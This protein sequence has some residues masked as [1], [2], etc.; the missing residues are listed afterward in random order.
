MFNP[1]SI[2]EVS[3]Q[4]THLKAR[5]KNTNPEVGDH[6]NPLQARTRKRESR[7]GNRGRQMLYKRPNLHALTARRMGMMMNTVGFY[8]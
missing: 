2:D 4:A 1:I 5:G 7:N 8:I 6:Q 3:I